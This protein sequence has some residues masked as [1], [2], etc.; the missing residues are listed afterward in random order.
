[1]RKLALLAA[2]IGVLAVASSAYAVQPGERSGSG[3]GPRCV[4]LPTAECIRCA[5][6]RGLAPER[7]NR[8]CYRNHA[9]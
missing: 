5:Q 9:K 1:M 3:G 6:M 4:S 2:T 8:F 7:Y